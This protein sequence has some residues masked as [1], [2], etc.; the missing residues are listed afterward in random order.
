MA[1]QLT[2]PGKVLDVA[3]GHGIFGIVIA[4]RFQEAQIYAL[5]FP[6]VLAVAEENATKFGVA[7]R[8]HAKPGSALEMELESD[9]DTVLLTNFLHHFGQAECISILKKLRAALLPGGKLLTLE[10]IPN[11]DRITPPAAAAFSMT[12]LLNTPAGDAF[13]FAELDGMLQAAGF[14]HNELHQVPMSPSQLIVSA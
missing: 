7:D 8:W 6:G 5:D 2:A 11:E 14:A 12:M 4:Q 13:T 3:A 9:Y 10:F 1:G